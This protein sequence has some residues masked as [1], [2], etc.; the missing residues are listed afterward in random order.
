MRASLTLI[1][2]GIALFSFGYSQ[3][4]VAQSDRLEFVVS[5]EI[6]KSIRFTSLLR[7][8]LQ[9]QDKSST[10]ILAAAQSD[11]QR[12]L[13]VLY[14]N[15]YYGA[16]ISITLNGKEAASLSPFET[17][18]EIT[19]AVVTIQQGDQ[20]KFGTAQ[21]RPLPSDTQLSPEFA[22]GEIAKSSVIQE[23][24]DDSIDAW[25]SA[26]RPTA[27]VTEQNITADHTRNSLDASFTIEP[28]RTAK[29]GSLIIRGN[30][31]MR[32]NR[33]RKIAGLPTGENFDPLELEAA[34]R[35]LRNTGAFTTV[36]ITEANE[37]SPD[38]TIPITATVAEA[39]P[40][41]IGAG[42]TISTDEGL[43]LEGFW[44][45]RNL[46]GGGESLRFDAVASGIGGTTDGIDYNV[47]VSLTRP[48]TLSPDTDA[49][50]SLN[51]ERDDEPDYSI[52][53]YTVGLNFDHDI[54]DTL[55][56]YAGVRYRNIDTNDVFGLR[57]FRLLSAPIGITYDSRDNEIS[58]SKGIYA[59]LEAQP[60]YER[61]RSQSGMRMAFDGRVYLGFGPDDKFVLAGRTQL[62]AVYGPDLEDLPSDYLYYSGGGGTVRGQ[63]YQVLGVPFGTDEQTGGKSFTGVSAELRAPLRD[64]LGGVIF[65]DYGYIGSTSSF[66]TSGDSHAGVGV[67]VRFETGLGPIRV[68]V[69]FPAD[70]VSTSNINFYIGIG[71]AF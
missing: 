40:R 64:N 14:E 54:N 7:Q 43:T 51:F 4:S 11:Y 45:H 8:A 38:G 9:E 17:L 13:S 58:A 49:T 12:F 31:R 32:E 3:F 48:A 67:G 46:L 71:Q 61:N 20:F 30:Q 24:V 34:G 26:S 42:A 62:G 68:D 36:A 5:E 39:K 23:A 44:L 2:T 19:S 27:K 57:N 15:G 18:G 50:F 56:T 22:K 6:S 33:V 47:G 41:R 63:D 21:I 25:R 66:L 53:A 55:S 52:R 69:G 28:G 29:F 60:F 65:A 70:D 10:E 16:Q 37:I 1:A 35:R 59:S